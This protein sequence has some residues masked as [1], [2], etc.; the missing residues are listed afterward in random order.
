MK[1]TATR[2]DIIHYAT[3]H[4]AFQSQPNLLTSS[5]IKNTYILL[6]KFSRQGMKPNIILTIAYIFISHKSPRDRETVFLRHDC[7]YHHHRCY[8]SWPIVRQTV[9]YNI[10]I[11]YWSDEDEVEKVEACK[12]YATCN[13]IRPSAQWIQTTW[14]HSTHASTFMIFLSKIWTRNSTFLSNIITSLHKTPPRHLSQHTT[15]VYFVSIGLI[16]W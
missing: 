6:L 15:I 7:T 5:E 10:Y 12:S 13:L 8:N 9:Q 11:P 14:R 4:D 1:I 2:H 16:R 3:S